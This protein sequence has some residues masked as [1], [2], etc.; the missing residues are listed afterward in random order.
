MKANEVR[1]QDFLSLN[2]TQFVIP[3]YQRNYDWL[4]GQ[5]KQFLDDILTVGGNEKMESHFIG[6]IVFIH[7]GVY[8]VSNVKELT[9]IDGQ[10]R[11]T[12]LILIYIVIH[13]LAKE[14]NDKPL[15]QEIEETYLVNKFAAEEEAKLKLRP[16]ENNDRA[17]KYLL[18]QSDPK[19][20]FRGFSRLIEN[21]DYFK[22]R[23]AKENYKCAMKGL[24]KLT[25]V[26]ISL[27]RGKDN[28]QRIFESLNSTG[29]DLSQADLIRNYILMGLP[30][31]SQNNIY[32]NYWEV[33][34]SL[35]KD[36]N[37]NGRVSDF[38]RDYLTLKT[39]IIPNQKKVYEEFK[40]EYKNPTASVEELER[41]LTE[42]KNLARHYNKLLNPKMEADKDIRLCLEYINRLDMTVAFPFLMQVYDDYSNR[43]IDQETFIKVLDLIQ[44]FVWRRFIVGLPTNALNKIFRNLYDKVDLS[45]YLPS[46]Q[47][48]L[49]QKTGGQRYPKDAEVVDSLKCKNVYDIAP[50]KKRYLLERLE[51]FKNP[52]RVLIEGNPEITIEHIFPQN[53]DP[54]WEEDL[55]NEESAYIKENYLNTIGNLTLSGNNVRLGNKP[56]LEK[57][58]LKEAGY[59]N[60]RLWLNQYLS[61]LDKWDRVAIEERFN[62]IKE[63]FL[64]IWEYPNISIAEGSENAETNIFEADDPTNKKL[65]YVI[66]RDEKIEV[67]T[68]TELYAK[69]FGRLFEQ[70]P[71]TFFSTDLGQKIGLTK[72]PRELRQ[73]C[74]I[75]DTGYFVETNIGNREKFEKIKRALTLFDLEEELVIKCS[76]N[77]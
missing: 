61:G 8:T 24:S 9:V 19:E 74:P 7:D 5:C 65:E 28:P 16:T 70:H 20:Q 67:G 51:N 39:K 13:K 69:V 63:R 50:T 2:K 64:K 42:I 47:K 41:K 37:Q 62:Q 44:S 46:I 56:F 55:G 58:D 23:I 73:A 66:F 52:E 15:A 77:T 26:E 48:S 12:T 76:A 30:R 60:S 22:T 57:R 38:I 40:K 49:V 25:F 11:L 34:E 3:V 14:L 33:I 17:L 18:Q 59:K 75:G 43:K 72:N 71:A 29:L 45:S 27:E 10:Q 4:R 6:S 54:K 31:K 1:V 21:F 53:P 32:Q 35:A 36:K 68:A